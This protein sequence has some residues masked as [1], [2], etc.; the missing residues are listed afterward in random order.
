MDDMTN[1]PNPITI[2]R[3]TI[4]MGFQTVFMH[5]GYRWL[6][7]STG[8]IFLALSLYVP[9]WFIPAN[10][11]ALVLHMMQWYDLVL[12]VVLAISS[13][14]AVAINI[15]LVRRRVAGV[16]TVEGGFG[17]AAALSAA[18]LLTSCGCGIGLIV[19]IFGIGIGGASFL[20][21]HQLT[22]SA[23]AL[24]VVL[25][26]LYMGARKVNAVCQT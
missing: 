8:A 7:A 10:T 22:I 16:A 15:F 2:H 3:P 26:S 20:T 5:A 25:V 17:L 12:L 19:G 13:G 18:V 14:L 21:T 6:A 11:I 4:R 1:Q 9:V 24:V 23:I